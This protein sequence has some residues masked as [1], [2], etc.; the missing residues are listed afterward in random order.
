MDLRFGGAASMAWRW[1]R[2]HGARAVAASRRWRTGQHSMA[3]DA[4]VAR[5]AA[6][7]PRSL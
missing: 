1:C 4:T 2:S 3:P 6:I 5:V 7:S